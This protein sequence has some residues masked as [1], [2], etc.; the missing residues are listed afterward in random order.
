M[1][2][3][4]AAK[5][6]GDDILS[7]VEAA[8]AATMVSVTFDP[9]SSSAGVAVTFLEHVRSHC[10]LG[11]LQPHNGM[12]I[13]GPVFGEAQLSEWLGQS[14]GGVCPLQLQQGSKECLWYGAHGM[15][16]SSSNAFVLSSM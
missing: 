10:R 11:W 7:R 14:A 9:I 8:A 2:S 16:T 6:I 13:A 4:V 12:A 1:S 5:K 15:L 3:S